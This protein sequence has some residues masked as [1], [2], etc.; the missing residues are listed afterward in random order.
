MQI[1]Q[2]RKDNAVVNSELNIPKRMMGVS[3]K[4]AFSPKKRTMCLQEVDEQLKQWEIFRNYLQRFE[5]EK[6]LPP[7]PYQPKLKKKPSSSP[8]WN[9]EAEK[10]KQS[11]PSK[12]DEGLNMGRAGFVA[13]NTTAKIVG[14]PLILAPVL[15]NPSAKQ[16]MNFPQGLGEQFGIYQLPTRYPQVPPFNNSASNPP[17]LQNFINPIPIL[18][19]NQG[20]GGYMRAGNGIQLI[21]YQVLHS[22]YNSQKTSTT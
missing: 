10:L 14:Q 9:T 17:F 4:S 13:P 15:A 11:A 3:G 22:S 18:G 6:N 16:P 2:E 19:G 8:E 7:S 12:V 5:Q 20:L 21:P 1:G